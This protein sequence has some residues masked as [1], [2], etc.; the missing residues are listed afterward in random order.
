MN[1][2]FLLLL[3]STL[4]AFSCNDEQAAGPGDASTYIK[5]FGAENADLAHMSQQTPDGG[6]VL[7]GSTEV[8]NDEGISTFKIK[9][10]KV[11]KNGN[12]LWQKIY[13]D[14]DEDPD[15]LISL[16]GR[17]IITVDDGYIIVGDSIQSNGV[18]NNNSLLLM[19]I[20]DSATDNSFEFTALN[21]QNLTGESSRYN[22]IGLDI[23]QDTDGN[24]RIISN[25]VDRNTVIG[26]IFSKI[27][28]DFSFDLNDC[29][30]EFAGNL[31]LVK[32]LHE[33]SD[34]N[35]IF[36]G[37][38]R[39]TSIDNSVLR[40][41]PA[42]FNNQSGGSDN[43]VSNPTNNYTAGQIISTNIGYAM[44]GTNVTGSGQTDVFF[45]LFNSDGGVRNNS[46]KLYNSVDEFDGI[47]DRDAL[48]L[49]IANTNDG[50]YI[51][52]GQTLED[53]AG[54]EDILLI[55]TDALGNI[56]WTQVIGNAN[57]ERATHIQQAA[58]GGFLIFGNTKFGGIDT[59]VLIKTDKDGNIN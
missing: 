19:R 54:E 43:L 45:A 48:G 38:N 22:V 8:L 7:L 20:N 28:T 57:Q 52:G 5:F 36:G 42:C 39:S 46:L 13:P 2:K 27:N 25:V 31:A 59:M 41:V 16:T 50:G 10:I 14:F 26:T 6:S 23:I 9:V 1:Y 53:T 18:T 17:S 55:K 49:T 11:D 35:F 33:T 58:D 30:Y 15:G 34:G 51:I 12:Q 4:L 3:F 40:R 56:Q 32:S 29:N 37:T 24:F 44:V 21:Y 47:G